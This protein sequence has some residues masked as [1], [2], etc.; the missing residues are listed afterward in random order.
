[1]GSS[2]RLATVY[3][4]DENDNPILHSKRTASRVS[5][6]T[7]NSQ[8][9][10]RGKGSRSTSQGCIFGK[11]S[12]KGPL[13][14]MVAAYS[15]GREHPLTIFTRSQDI[16]RER[17]EVPGYPFRKIVFTDGTE[18]LNPDAMYDRGRFVCLTAFIPKKEEN[19]A[20]PRIYVEQRVYEGGQEKIM[21]LELDLG[22]RVQ[23]DMEYVFPGCGDEHINL[24]KRDLRLRIRSLEQEV[25]DSYMLRANYYGYDTNDYVYLNRQTISHGL[26]YAP[27]SNGEVV[28]YKLCIGAQDLRI[29]LDAKRKNQLPAGSFLLDRIELLELRFTGLGER[30][31]DNTYAGDLFVRVMYSP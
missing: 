23:I 19:C 29:L 3:D 18:I 10:S 24:G 21:V 28:P 15:R 2:P 25:F 6:A 8:F 27:R 16:S 14:E 9:Q 22:G 11:L 17:N 4:L 5:K 20:D 26:S 1:M 30:T 7:S 13:K 12:C 31:G